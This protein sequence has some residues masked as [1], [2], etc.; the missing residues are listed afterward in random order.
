MWAGRRSKLRASWNVPH[1]S[2]PLTT[3]GGTASCR[4]QTNSEG[5]NVNVSGN[6][7]GIFGHS[8]S[9]HNEC[10]KPVHF[11]VV[12]KITHELSFDKGHHTV[13]QQGHLSRWTTHTLTFVLKTII[14]IIM[15]IVVAIQTLEKL[16]WAKVIT[17]C[18]VHI[19]V[20]W[21]LL[22]DPTGKY[23]CAV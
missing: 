10:D 23:S 4:L 19:Y 17:A 18:K 2:A 12:Y 16:Y 1:F 7:P 11:V 6:L 13:P 5:H 15:I 21:H 14:I 3:A 8:N 20:N 9:L 22:K